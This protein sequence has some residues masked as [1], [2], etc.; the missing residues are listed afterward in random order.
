[1]L[2]VCPSNTGPF[3]FTLQNLHTGLPAG[4]LVKVE[5][6]HYCHIPLKSPF[7]L[8]VTLTVG[9]GVGITSLLLLF[10]SN[11]SFCKFAFFALT[12]DALLGPLLL[13]N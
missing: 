2:I 12:E 8:L 10:D 11:G 4:S 6:V 3:I 13:S 5:L 9:E 7:V 1:M